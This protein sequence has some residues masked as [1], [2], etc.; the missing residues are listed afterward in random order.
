MAA[1]MYKFDCLNSDLELVVTKC[2]ELAKLQMYILEL[3]RIILVGCNFE[4][5]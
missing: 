4:E 5:I 1:K 2:L 3:M